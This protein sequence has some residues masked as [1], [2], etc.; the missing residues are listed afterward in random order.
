LVLSKIEK[1]II[2]RKTFLNL[3]SVVEQNLK[4]GTEL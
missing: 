3:N 1:Q 2:W 4:R